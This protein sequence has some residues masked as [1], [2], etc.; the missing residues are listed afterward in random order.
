MHE[1]E[2][3]TAHAQATAS[4]PI[5]LVREAVH[6]PLNTWD[7][8]SAAPAGDKECHRCLTTQSSHWLVH[9]YLP[10]CHACFITLHRDACPFCGKRAPVKSDNMVLCSRCDR[11]TH[12][13]CEE[14]FRGFPHGPCIV[15]EM[16]ERLQN[17]SNRRLPPELS[18]RALP[19]IL[20][21]H[22][23]HYGSHFG[24]RAVPAS[25]QTVEDKLERPVERRIAESTQLVCDVLHLSPGPGRISTAFSRLSGEQTRPAT[26]RRLSLPGFGGQSGGAWAYDHKRVA[27]GAPRS[28]RP[29]CV[30]TD[31]AGLRQ[32]HDGKMWN[33]KFDFQTEKPGSESWQNSASSS[34]SQSDR[35][36]PFFPRGQGFES[37]RSVG[38][39][40]PATMPESS[41]RSS[42]QE[43]L[44]YNRFL[45]ST[46]FEDEKRTPTPPPAK[47]PIVISMLCGRNSAA[48]VADKAISPQFS[49]ERRRSTVSNKMVEDLEPPIEGRAAPYQPFLAPRIN[50]AFVKQSPRLRTH[51]RG[52]SAQ[53][54]HYQR[55]A[56][57]KTD[58]WRDTD[59]LR[60]E[61]ARSIS[62]FT[63][64]QEHKYRATWNHVKALTHR[65]NT[66]R[67]YWT[68]SFSKS[69]APLHR[70][71]TQ[72]EQF[73]QLGLSHLGQN[74]S[75]YPEDED[76]GSLGNLPSCAH[77]K[78]KAKLREPAAESCFVSQGNDLFS[79]ILDLINRDMEDFGSDILKKCNPNYTPQQFFEA[80]HGT[81][82][83]N[84][85]ADER[86]VAEDPV[87]DDSTTGF[88]GYVDAIREISFQLA[89]QLYITN[90]DKTH[91]VK[92]NQMQ[93]ILIVM[94]EF[95]VF[96]TLIGTRRM[97]K[98]VLDAITSAVGCRSE[99][100]QGH[101]QFVLQTAI[102]DVAM[103]VFR[104]DPE[105][106]GVAQVI[107]QYADDI[108]LVRVLLSY[109]KLHDVE[110]MQA[111]KRK[112]SNATEMQVAIETARLARDHEIGFA[113]MFAGNADPVRDVIARY[114]HALQDIFHF[115]AS[116]AEDSW[117]VLESKK[118]DQVLT[119]VHMPR[120]SLERND[121]IHTISKQNEAKIKAMREKRIE[122]R[123]TLQN[124]VPSG[125]DL[126]GTRAMLQ[127]VKVLKTHGT[128]NRNEAAYLAQCLKGPDMLHD[129]AWLKNQRSEGAVKKTKDQEAKKAKVF[130]W[131]A[132]KS[133]IYRQVLHAKDLVQFFGGEGGIGQLVWDCVQKVNHA[134]LR[135]LE[136]IKSVWTDHL[137]DLALTKIEEEE[138]CKME[139]ELAAQ[140]A[141]E[142]A[143]KK[144]KRPQQQHS[145]V[146]AQQKKALDARLVEENRPQRPCIE[147]HLPD[148]SQKD[149]LEESIGE[150]RG[151]RTEIDTVISNLLAQL[152]ND[153]LVEMNNRKAGLAGLERISTT[154]GPLTEDEEPKL[155]DAFKRRLSYKTVNHVDIISA[156]KLLPDGDS[157]PDS[158]QIRH[159]VSPNS[160]KLLQPSGNP[161]SSVN[162]SGQGCNDPQPNGTDWQVDSPVVTS[163]HVSTEAVLNQITDS[164]QNAMAGTESERNS[165][166]TGEDCVPELC[167]SPEMAIT[168]GALFKMALIFGLIGTEDQ[169]NEGL[170][171][172]DDVQFLQ[173]CSEFRNH[174]STLQLDWSAFLDFLM[175]IA[176]NYLKDLHLG[177]GL[178]L[179]GTS[180][181]H[182]QALFSF[183]AIP[184][185]VMGRREWLEVRVHEAIKFRLFSLFDRPAP[186]GLWLLP[187]ANNPWKESWHLQNEFKDIT[188]ADLV[189]LLRSNRSRAAPCDSWE[190]VSAFRGPRTSPMG[191][192]P[193]VS[194][195]FRAGQ[196]MSESFEDKNGELQ[197]RAL[198]PTQSIGRAPSS[199]ASAT[200]SVTRSFSRMSMG[201]NHRHFENL[202]HQSWFCVMFCDSRKDPEHERRSEIFQA[203]AWQHPLRF[204]RV[205]LPAHPSSKDF[206]QGH[207]VTHVPGL[208]LYCVTGFY[209][210][211]DHIWDLDHM[212]FWLN[213]QGIPGNARDE[214]HALEQD[215]SPVLHFLEVSDGLDSY[216][217]S[218]LTLSNISRMSGS[219]FPVLPIKGFASLFFGEK[220]DLQNIDLSGLEV[221][222]LANLFRDNRKLKIINL[223]NCRM[224]VDGIA[225][226]LL[227]LA[228]NTRVNNL[229]LA[230]NIIG[231][232]A[233]MKP[234][235]KML[236]ANRRI[237]HAE[238]PPEEGVSKSVRALE[239][240]LKA[241]ASVER[242]CLRSCSLDNRA[243]QSV[244]VG[245]EENLLLPI[246]VLDLSDNQFGDA[247]LPNL[248]TA[249]KKR[250]NDF[251]CAKI[252][253]LNLRGN[254]ITKLGCSW[255]ENYLKYR[256]NVSCV[257]GTTPIFF[258]RQKLMPVEGSR[259]WSVK[260]DGL[261]W[262]RVGV[263]IGGKNPSPGKELINDEFSEALKQKQDFTQ[264]ELEK[265]RIGD[266][267]FDHFV[268][269]GAFFYQPVEAASEV[270][271]L[272]CVDTFLSDADTL[273]LE[274]RFHMLKTLGKELHSDKRLGWQQAWKLIESFLETALC[275]QAVQWAYE[276]LTS[277]ADKDA[278]AKHFDTF[279]HDRAQKDYGEELAVQVQGEDTDAPPPLPG[280]R[281]LRRD[282]QFPDGV[283]A[284]VE[285]FNA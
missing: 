99:S 166:M 61:T 269:S 30:D 50:A 161:T 21:T 95:G 165:E 271:A 284:T 261:K 57:P 274:D 245:L 69:Q 249:L 106:L 34:S 88:E 179:D 37:G 44:N 46:S 111:F 258:D 196:T 163:D 282:D 244:A 36:V 117:N 113:S 193:S 125:P 72:G 281:K 238:R 164:K 230:H 67:N 126:M 47:E 98:I 208:R 90:D 246:T 242:L 40:R 29:P 266:L 219:R 155:A 52:I 71:Q 257:D 56:R 157:A 109:M 38:G 197:G 172:M 223:Q 91:G 158:L 189:K 218:S 101:Y 262:K 73:R 60:A 62:S 268:K 45:R 17:E 110:R 133:Q 49:W 48:S 187:K 121:R 237:A 105:R 54:I 255:I 272:T 285:V 107:D 206:V 156:Q 28:S 176:R 116:P 139:L 263:A 154:A 128:I 59:R 217:A 151:Q 58:S 143:S 192:A 214:E 202:E 216:L 122:I 248:T 86:P 232:Q 185:D 209:R 7:D 11:A 103:T 144:S 210:D 124:D 132:E 203:L 138:R 94:N 267:D 70:P 53:N 142:R 181:S 229:N 51:F 27:S 220:L 221:F 80:I 188:G 39:H 191:R 150:V 260:P 213:D 170:V 16:E 199:S 200:G 278:Y 140:K 178:S 207:N 273:L 4:A 115:F 2:A 275:F 153:I 13:A 173:V 231:V 33:E 64:D 18:L 252:Q 175:H 74:S 195:S 78:P 211:C 84:S 235:A 240:F 201:S 190:A 42:L 177:P 104:E 10:T 123:K 43:L 119:K 66:G 148:S 85:N 135:E 127:R 92:L 8:I 251:D 194:G 6:N 180:S 159:Q 171:L 100:K 182:T 227:A 77:R 75:R 3:D 12:R 169:V 23:F 93:G 55:H 243:V 87:P 129:P 226:I 152:E 24:Q 160:S 20:N 35:H 89:C 130:W 279:L 270:S 26:Q 120:Q 184:N 114:Q 149:P 65:T 134:E 137:C 108:H 141:R 22:I 253:H 79:S 102:H 83:D 228:L 174:G 198:S 283:T 168:P 215:Y 82:Y 280:Q 1:A 212:N 264:E 239:T 222:P 15:C 32:R 136:F 81:P 9:Q 14:R 247:S 204:F 5:R 233:K 19:A 259:N 76:L 63:A 183:M 112:F 31:H 41:P 145:K 96:P 225:A 224:G 97:T 162:G 186:A 25:A 250:D 131:F 205:D 254:H 68:P 256:Q 277:V 118:R 236:A 167:I 265:F 147:C 241:N 276:L 234:M 146:V